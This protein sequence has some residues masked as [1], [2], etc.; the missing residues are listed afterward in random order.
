LRLKLN[1]VYQNINKT[2]IPTGFLAEYAHPLLPMQA[3][4]GTLVDSVRTDADVWRQLYGTTYTAYIGNTTHPMPELSALNTIVAGVQN[5]IP[6]SM[7]HWNYNDMKANA[8]TT[9][10]LS[11]TNDQL[12]D[13]AGRSQ[14]PYQ[15]KTLFAAA[16]SISYSNTGSTAF[17]FRPDLFIKN[18]GTINTIQIDFADGLG[19][20]AVTL[21]TPIYASYATTGVKR[22]KVKITPATGSVM[23]SWF[24]FK[25]NTASCTNCIY[26]GVGQIFNNA[27]FAA[28]ANHSG[29]EIRVIFAVGNNT[30]AVGALSHRIRK[31]LIIAKGFDQAV[32]APN[33]T[34]EGEFTISDFI[35]GINAPNLT[36][37]FNNALDNT[38]GYDLVFIKYNRPTDDIQRNAALL[39]AVIRAV[40]AQKQ[41]GDAQNVVMGTS[42]G[43]L[44]ARFGLAQMVRNSENPQTRLL[45]THDS[46]HRGA[47]VPLGAQCLA[48]L[49]PILAIEAN[50]ATAALPAKNKLTVTDL[51]TKAFQLKAL[52]DEPATAQLLALRGTTPSASQFNTFL[53]PGGIY[54]TMVDNLVT[55]YQTIATS[56][57]S[58]CGNQLFAPG[59]NLIS[60]DGGF[61]FAPFTKWISSLGLRTSLVINAARVTG[62]PAYNFRLY[63]QYKIFTIP[64]N[65]TLKTASTN[66]PSTALALDGAPGGILPLFENDPN[67][68][69]PLDYWFFGYNLNVSGVKEFC[70]V[71]TASALDVPLS[72]SALSDS[73]V[74]S[75]NVTNPPSFTR[76]IAQEPFTRT[77]PGGG[78]A[79]NSRHIA[80]TPR[81]SRWM[82]EQMEPALGVTNLECTTQCPTVGLTLSGSSP[83]CTSNT[84]TVN[85]TA[86]T[87]VTWS[88]SPAGI[89][90]LSSSTNTATLTRITNGNVA[91]IASVGACSNPTV[92]RTVQIGGS[93]IIPP[94]NIQQI[95]Q[96]CPPVSTNSDFIIN[97][98]ASG[99][100]YSWQCS[101]CDG[102][103]TTFGTQ[104]DQASVQI[105]TTPRSFD[106]TVTATDNNCVT[107]TLSKT[108]TF[109]AGTNCNV[110]RTSNPLQVNIS[111]NPASST[112]NVSVVDNSIPPPTDNNHRIFIS[113]AYGNV[114]GSY[115]FTQLDNQISVSSLPV[116]TFSLRVSKGINIVTKT[117]TIVR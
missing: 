46:P 38:A 45:I 100:T 41:A 14:S 55:P 27:N 73:Y 35:N 82:F 91:L 74:N 67:V 31:P 23:E 52:L 54:R 5:A 88:V 43:G 111:P 16:P 57:G 83:F 60:V 65:I 95:Q 11:I 59:M 94:I 19:Y 113:D 99:V 89:A 1:T 93:L 104:A 86:G 70:F 115:N 105:T 25:A 18:T 116:G 12:F 6:I 3:F 15:S 117:F 28:N 106:I 96:A 79:F 62:V 92:S 17:I 66:Y 53:A 2:Q 47:N 33:L 87:P 110:L 76:F 10:L 36:F 101:N 56:N 85:S 71:P 8:V 90:S 109:S 114:K 78:T 51:S 39:Q 69:K 98:P 22:I 32:I 102:P 63:T 24:D 26:T 37:Q 40:N 68:G 61:F 20:Q 108:T 64:I 13:V 42:M 30:P 21:G 72:A 4:N 29:G 49:A 7:L 50:I 112:I 77:T 107:N 44:V 48:Q 58:Q 84:F 9:N 80:F 34:Q 103:V 97:P 75:V 81:N